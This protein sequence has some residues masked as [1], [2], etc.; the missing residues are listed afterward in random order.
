M[1]KPKF[2]VSNIY[3]KIF[4]DLEKY[5]EFCKDY[6]YVYNEAD[7][8]NMRNYVFRQFN[9]HNSGKPVRDQWAEDSKA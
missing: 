5:L 9:K 2:V 6:G 1:A 3:H 4:D 7:L 8:Y